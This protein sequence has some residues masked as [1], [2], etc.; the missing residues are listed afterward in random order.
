MTRQGLDEQVDTVAT[1]VAPLKT[2][3]VADVREAPLAEPGIHE[4]VASASPGVADTA[5]GAAGS[6]AGMTAEEAE[7][8][9]ELPASLVATAV[10][11]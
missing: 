3:T 4:T 10:N 9:G 5:V 7:E 11:V 8:S 1:S 6:P 2:E